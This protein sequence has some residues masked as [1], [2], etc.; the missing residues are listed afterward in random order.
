MRL[1]ISVHQ[2]I[3][4]YK[5]SVTWWWWVCMPSKY[6]D[7]P[8]SNPAEVKVNLR[9]ISLEKTQNITKKMLDWS[10]F[11]KIKVITEVSILST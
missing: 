9:I 8:S 1:A 2:D 11:I 5:V 4:K 3:V 10:T 7:D 6:S